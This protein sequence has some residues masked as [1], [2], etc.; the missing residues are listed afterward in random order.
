MEICSS[1]LA[2]ILQDADWD[3]CPESAVLAFTFDKLVIQDQKK[4]VR[5]AT[6]RCNW[7]NVNVVAKQ[8]DSLKVNVSCGLSTIANGLK[9]K[10]DEI[11]EN[12]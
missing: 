6:V 3:R 10:N 4:L 12:C 2:Y 7:Q 11:I 1:Q 5:E 8:L 9:Q